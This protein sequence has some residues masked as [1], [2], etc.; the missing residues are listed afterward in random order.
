MLQI[1]RNQV[2]LITRLALTCLVLSVTAFGQYGTTTPDR[3][4]K[5]GNS[6]SVGQFDTVNTT[7]GAL[8]LNFPLASLPAGRGSATNGVS[9]TY[10]SK[11]YRMQSQSNPD[12]LHDLTRYDRTVIEPDPKGGWRLG[13]GTY[14]IEQETRWPGYRPDCTVDNWELNQQLVYQHKLKIVFPDGSTHEMIPYGHKDA[15]NDRY[16]KVTMDGMLESCTGLPTYTTR[17]VY[18]SRDGSFLRL[19][20]SSSTSWTL[21]FADGSKVVNGDQIYDRNGNYV[22]GLTD[23]FQRS[24][25]FGTSNGYQ[26]ITSKGVGGEDVT[27]KIKWRE[28]WVFKTY[29]A[30]NSNHTHCH[31]DQTFYD[32]PRDWLPVSHLVVD[33]IVEPDQQGAGTYKFTYNAS[34]TP[35][36][37]LTYG[38]GEVSSIELPSGAKVTYTYS[39]D[40]EDGPIMFESTKDILKNQ[41]SSKTLT[42]DLEYDGQVGTG[43]N[44]AT[45]TW[46]YSTGPVGSSVTAPDGSVTSTEFATT[47]PDSSGNLPW[48][49]GLTYTSISPDGTKVEN[50]W[51]RNIPTGCHGSS[52]CANSHADN[53][54]I[55]TTFTSIKEGSAYTLTAIKD[56]TYDINGNATEVREYDYVPY[57]SVPRTNGRPTGLPSNANDYLKR[58]TKTEFHNQAPLAPTSSSTD[59]YDSNIY[60]FANPSRLLNLPKSVEVRATV[61]GAA[62]SR[63][64]MIY[65]CVDRTQCSNPKAG[66]VTMTRN[67]DSTKGSVSI[68]L[69]DSNSIKTQ[70]S[71]ND[72]GQLITTTDANNVVTQI[73]YS[74]VTVGGNSVPGPYPTQTIVAHG[75]GLA[76]TSTAVYDFH[77]G[78]VTSA[79]DE[80]N[81]LTVVTV[82]DALGRPTI[83][84]N[85]FGTPL[86]SWTQTTYNDVD[87]YIVVKSDLEVRED[88]RKVAIQHFDPVGRVRLTRT[89]EDA[90]NE[91]PTNEQHGIKMQ[92]RYQ[93]TGVTCPWDNAEGPPEICSAQLVSNPYR[94]GFS[95]GA[96]SEETMGWTLTYSQNNGRRSEVRTFGGGVCQD[97]GVRTG[98]RQASSAPTSM[99]IAR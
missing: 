1:R 85:A 29:V 58:V 78:A 70:A 53:P 67:W 21:Y 97:L 15:L 54:Y 24:I 68:P 46:L 93:A 44:G 35:T 18:Y 63:S 47:D 4:V 60:I 45:E 87:R 38:W 75:T 40:N 13:A 7:T 3:G 16:F 10:N 27:W 96:S 89:L 41:V 5:L 6:F 19:E 57:S 83:V 55:K 77:T 92:T 20:T 71:Y 88:G 14:S 37:T 23:Q 86:E 66:N 49:T 82:Y 50:I 9:L 76:R 42:Y 98:T 22:T 56:F 52:T 84:K 94:A 39:L 64:E 73:T 26:T 34:N 81:D 62:N 31:D 74:N 33:E 95:S 30:C 99:R 32:Y 28:I 72:Y 90:A 36:Q 25:T 79:T 69:T 65:D 2:A 59:F 43:I 91:S 17:P 48:D 8:M 61:S 11:L 12:Q 80:D 51:D